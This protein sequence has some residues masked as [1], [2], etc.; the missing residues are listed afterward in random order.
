MAEIERLRKSLPSTTYFWINAYKSAADYYDESL[1]EPLEAI[2]PLFPLNNQRHPS[3]GRNCRTGHRVVTVD[4]RGDVRRCH[5]V[6]D[7]I[8]NLYDG[9]FE[10]GLIKRPCPNQT[11]GCHIGYVHLDHLQLDQ[12]FGEGILERIPSNYETGEVPVS[13]RL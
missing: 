4:S 2:D 3:Q 5:F 7:V 1:L 10:A 8:G 6:E 13:G 12:V 9:S 11:C